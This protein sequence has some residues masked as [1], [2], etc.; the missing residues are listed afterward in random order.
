MHKFAILKCSKIFQSKSNIEE[1][2]EEEEIQDMTGNRRCWHLFF[3]WWAQNIGWC[4]TRNN[5]LLKWSEKKSETR[6]DH[7]WLNTSH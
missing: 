6:I 7:D 5:E 3:S 2:E 1:E 4:L